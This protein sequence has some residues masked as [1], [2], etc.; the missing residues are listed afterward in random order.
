M[1]VKTPKEMAQGMVENEV[2]DNIQF[3]LDFYA[4]EIG[5]QLV[6]GNRYMVEHCEHMYRA[7]K[8]I[9]DAF[10]HFKFN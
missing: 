7:Y 6:K 5:K 10:N 2:R 4:E 1:N 8:Q 3:H 9:Q